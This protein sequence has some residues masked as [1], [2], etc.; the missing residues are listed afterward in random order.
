M[1]LK[2]YNGL[3]TDIHIYNLKDVIDYVNHEEEYKRFIIDKLGTIPSYIFPSSGCLKAASKIVPELER[4]Q[5]EI[6]LKSTVYNYVDDLPEG[7]DF[8][9]V[10]PAYREAC[11]QL[12]KGLKKLILP[13]QP[14]YKFANCD[15]VLG[16]LNFTNC[17]NE[18]WNFDSV[19][20]PAII[21]VQS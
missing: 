7:Y 18:A 9:I 17:A 11:A 8:Y 2:I 15:E 5:K 20:I 19:L 12:R 16:F 3:L 1:T 13:S 4:V 10:Y 21:K 6:P 14:V